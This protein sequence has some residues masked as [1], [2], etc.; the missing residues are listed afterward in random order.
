VA[1][2]LVLDVFHRGTLIYSDILSDFKPVELG[3][4]DTDPKRSPP[5]VLHIKQRTAAGYRVA[6][7]DKT[8][9]SVSRAHVSVQLISNRRIKITNISKDNHIVHNDDQIVPGESRELEVPAHFYIGQVHVR[10]AEQQEFNSLAPSLIR[11]G[12]MH[13][14]SA[15]AITVPLLALPT[16]QAEQLAEWLERVVG[17]LQS[18]VST[19]D[20]YQLA[21]RAMVNLVGLDSGMVLTLQGQEWK[22]QAREVST[23][24][25]EKRYRS[26]PSRQILGNLLRGK[27]T[28]WGDP[29]GNAS[30]VEESLANVQTVVA[31]PILN[32]HGEVIGALYGDRMAG[33]S[34]ET[35][36]QINQAEAMLVKMLATSV[37][38][39]LARVEQEHVAKLQEQAAVAAH[40]RFS[41]FFT[42]ELSA[43]LA[44]DPDMLNGRV[45]KVTL[46]FCDIR[47]FSRISERLEPTIVV[48]WIGEVMDLLSDS[49]I[50]H[51]GVLVN[52]IG[53]ELL[54]M[55]GAP[56]EQPD[57]A[58]LACRAA[59]NMQHRLPALN[60]RWE[61]RLGMR[62][63]IGIGINT[64]QA[65]VGNTGSSRKLQYGPLG[66]TVNLASR[67]QGITKY[68]GS[69]ILITAATY[70][71]LSDEFDTR[72]LT[73][74]RVV[75]ISEPVDLYELRPQADEI[76]HA[77]REKYERA[78]QDFEQQKFRESVAALGELIMQHPDD[79]PSLVL[80]SRAVA[81]LNA[82][83]AP[84]E[85]WDPSWVPSAK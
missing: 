8:E 7:L 62:F 25:D 9:R 2:E 80:L 55:W 40:A 77:L 54:A 36:P 26:H 81:E 71:Q 84:G 20:F 64:G 30:N 59:L 15:A 76:W 70:G 39:G 13:E 74:V 49:V 11:P 1:V 32:R 22:L 66:N 34:K 67:V 85:K 5:D 35:L 10:V 33:S 79:R 44:A 6:I 82:G 14:L 23:A 43:Q 47:E 69:E 72:R 75:N 63:R 3:R 46:M 28:V 12:E 57:Q 48:E 42:P 65:Q 37:A 50:E 60:D 78:L 56:S 61:S 51:N 53:D 17:V 31:A 38:A 41:Q 73:K 16:Q 29:S 45:S 68:L 4:L 24:V 18:A 52:Y 19:S 58:Q 21:T 83:I 27:S